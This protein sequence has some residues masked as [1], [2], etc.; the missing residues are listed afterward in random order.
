MKKVLHYL[1]F[2]SFLLTILVPVTGIKIHKLASTLFLI[3]SFIHL[4]I[5]SNKLN[6][7]R[8]LL[9]IMIV[10]CFITGIFGMIFDSI[11]IVINM[12]KVLSVLLVF[13]LAIHIY[14][15]HRK[16]RI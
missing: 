11:E 4:I 14:V 3:F 13:F 15:Y 1:L 6:L 5:Y 12:H 7:K 16:M 8:V 9:M 10:I 2:I